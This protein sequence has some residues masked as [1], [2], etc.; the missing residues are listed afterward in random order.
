MTLEPPKYEYLNK[1]NTKKM[2]EIFKGERTGWVLVGPKKW[3]F[4]HKYTIEGKG[5]YNFKARPD[6]IWV[7]SYPR[8]GTTWTQELVWLLSNNLDF[9]RA[10]TELLA[11][12]FPFLEFSMFNHPEVTREFLEL[13]KGDKDKEELCKKIAQPGYDILEKIPSKRFIKSHFPFSL[14]PNILESGCK[15]IYIARNPKDVAVSWYYLNKAI[16]T[17][18]YIGD[19]TT[20]WYY[21]QNN[22]TPWSP[23]WE[24]LKEAWTH[25]NHPNVL[26]M[27]YEEMQY[28]FSKAIK[29]IAKFLGKDYTEEE[30]KKVEDYLNIKNFRN[31]PMVNLS[32]LKKCDII[33]S[34]TFV[35][36]GQSNG[37][38]DMFSEELNAKANKWIEENLKGNNF[39]FPYFNDLNSNYN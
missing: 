3:F 21:F 5:F 12:R 11:E 39:S 1:E 31:N 34:G 19:F 33:T 14:L 18:G 35:R 10:K 9:K 32:E 6:D 36:K 25:R 15:I 8:S 24:H 27:F 4:P 13:N 23:Y 29:K 26:F 2:L 28:D 20:F 7:L 30:I 22:L 16:K 17:Q 38:K 37:W